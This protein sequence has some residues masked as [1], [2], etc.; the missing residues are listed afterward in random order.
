[1]LAMAG[2]CNGQGKSPFGATRAQDTSYTVAQV[3]FTAYGGSLDTMLLTIMPNGDVKK[4]AKNTFSGGLDFTPEQVLNIQDFGATA[5]DTTNDAV[6]IQSCIDSA[7][8]LGGRVKIYCPA[9]V[10]YIKSPLQKTKNGRACNAQLVI[11]HNDRVQDGSDGFIYITIEGQ[12]IPWSIDSYLSVFGAATE[13]K[14]VKNTTCFRSTIDNDGSEFPAVIGIAQGGDIGGGVYINHLGILMK[15]I[16]IQVHYD[17]VL[18]GT[19]LCGVDARNSMDAVAEGM[20]WCLDTS[21]LYSTVKTHNVFGYRGS[22]EYGMRNVVRESSSSGFT[23]GV[24]LGEHG[25]VDNVP[26]YNCDYALVVGYNIMGL[27][28]DNLIPHGCKWSFGAGLVDP[29]VARISG[30]YH[31]EK[32]S[33]GP[34]A[35][36]GDFYDPNNLVSGDL[37][38][39]TNGPTPGYTKTFVKNGGRNVIISTT[40]SGR[41][42]RYGNSTYG[43]IYTDSLDYIITNGRIRG[44]ISSST[45]MTRPNAL[46]L[47]SGY[48]GSGRTDVITVTNNTSGTGQDLSAATYNAG[49]LAVT[50]ATTTGYNAGIRTSAGSSSTWNFGMTSLVTGASAGG[51]VGIMSWAAAGSR[52]VGIFGYLGAPITTP[53]LS[54]DAA[55]VADN[56]ATTHPSFMAQDN[57]TR[58]FSIL[59]GGG[60]VVGNAT[61]NVN[62]FEVITNTAGNN[63]IRTQNT[64]SG[65]TSAAVINLNNNNGHLGQIKKNSSGFTTSGLAKAD[66]F[67][68][69][70]NSTGDIVISNNVATGVIDIG[71]NGTLRMKIKASGV[72][73]IASV[74]T[75]ADNTAALAGGLVAGDVYRTST[76]QL[77]IV[78]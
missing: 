13:S 44:S 43:G 78:F 60:V 19:Q 10:Y 55:I 1:M 67:M 32:T 5:D 74:S 17:S 50:N 25:V 57:G 38:Y 6:S 52:N 11:P 22:N 65:S 61:T 34:G 7:H 68:I 2:I 47:S 35:T 49:L 48:T 20:R 26:V 21:S 77:M 73:N 54:A 3:K 59:D 18:G 30:Y 12:S 66:D 16:T 53:T 56:G 33:A 9:G 76:G 64:N 70:N 15:N 63:G 4:V 71:T 72:I 51:N 42:Y 58:V 41:I 37:Q 23:Y 29:G 46:T 28:V 36:V 69:L 24:V 45:A 75:Y 8:A 14:L 62:L 31:G 39:V 27:R 40:D